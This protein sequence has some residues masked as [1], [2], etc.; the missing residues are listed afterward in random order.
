MRVLSVLLIVIGMF[1][2]YLGVSGK[3]IGE[4]LSKVNANDSGSSK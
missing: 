3:S 4:L 2:I 1:M